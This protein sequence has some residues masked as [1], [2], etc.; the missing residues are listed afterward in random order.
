[1][2]KINN[3]KVNQGKVNYSHISKNVEKNKVFF[4]F[5]G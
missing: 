1:M 5:F 4:F 2:C 3:L